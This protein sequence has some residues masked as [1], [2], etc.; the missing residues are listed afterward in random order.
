MDLNLYP[1]PT[2]D[3][4][5]LD[6]SFSRPVD[7]RVDLVNAI[8]Q[9]IRSETHLSVVEHKMLFDMT[10]QA[11]GTYFIRLMVEGELHTL[12]FILQH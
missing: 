4:T 5:T 1:N 10:D 8:G 7:I 9:Q 11:A 6:M 12:P 3:Y 2:L